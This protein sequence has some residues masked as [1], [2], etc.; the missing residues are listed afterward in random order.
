[1]VDNKINFKI[2]KT[3]IVKNNNLNKDS[4]NT[5]FK[6]NTIN[7]EHATKK[8]KKSFAIIDEYI[9]CPTSIANSLYEKNQNNIV[10][11]KYNRVN[12]LKIDQLFQSIKSN[13]NDTDKLNI[14]AKFSNHLL[15]FKKADLNGT[16]YPCLT[17]L[18][19]PILNEID[20]IYD[21]NRAFKLYYLFR[22]IE[23]LNVIEDKLFD[24]Y[25]IMIK[26]KDFGICSQIKGSVT[27]EV[28]LSYEFS[29][30]INNYASWYALTE[31]IMFE[32][33]ILNK[34]FNDFN[35]QLKFDYKIFSIKNNAKFNPYE[36]AKK[37]FAI[38]GSKLIK[39]IDIGMKLFGPSSYSSIALL[40]L[41]SY[42]SG[43]SLPAIFYSTKSFQFAIAGTYVSNWIVRSVSKYLDYYSNTAEY[44]KISNVIVALNNKLSNISNVSVDLIKLFIL[45]ELDE[46][47]QLESTLNSDISNENLINNCKLSIKF[48]NDNIDKLTTKTNIQLNQNQLYMDKE[49]N[50]KLLIN[51]IEEQKNLL[52]KHLSTVDDLKEEDFKKI[53]DEAMQWI[54]R[55]V[56]ISNIEDKQIN[57]NG[58][59]AIEK[60]VK[61]QNESDWTLINLIRNKCNKK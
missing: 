9:C 56:N 45:R 25:K 3:N 55:S 53:E 23:T 49:Y 38:L 40:V 43:L 29:S 50:H 42:T 24:Y 47:L 1:M 26:N 61:K 39:N 46:Y 22:L 36:F 30:F 10:N 12:S 14:E 60:I 21:S 44:S 5:K 19:E 2:N 13:L 51:K 35:K 8:D 32:I 17:S 52:E 28:L 4:L 34:F 7:N 54:E 20:K 11:Y 33:Y 6:K 37:N 41:S 15:A 57:A 31:I 27:N 48:N 58:K 18:Y 59:E 16:S